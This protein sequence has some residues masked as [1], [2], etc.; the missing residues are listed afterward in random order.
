MS[1]GLDKTFNVGFAQPFG[2]NLNFGQLQQPANGL[3]DNSS[4]FNTA[5]LNSL[6]SVNNN[7]EDDFMMPEFL[8]VN[9]GNN[10]APEVL[11]S[12]KTDSQDDL[13]ASKFAEPEF[14]HA[15]SQNDTV[16]QELKNYSLDSNNKEMAL[17]EFGNPYK[18]TDVSKKTL[19]LLGFT[20]PIAGKCVQL[21]NGGKF[22]ELFK[23]KQ[24]AVACPMLALA[25]YGIG[26]LI[27]SFINNQRA[28]AAD[29]LLLAKNMT[30][31]SKAVQE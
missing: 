14:Q 20:A 7:Y 1:V 21:S 8:K 13:S 30:N 25:G 24:L 12:D 26:S 23:I 2:N 18:E 17:T 5:P 28:K 3:S 31:S 10:A 16:K 29:S 15:A 4:I 9:T 11:F 22:A 19:A 27:D 6:Q